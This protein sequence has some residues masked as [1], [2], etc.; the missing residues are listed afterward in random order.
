MPIICN[1][2]IIL[3]PGARHRL[4]EVRSETGKLQFPRTEK[5]FTFF[6]EEDS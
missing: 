2:V 5:E 4:T 3:P 1:K 6:R